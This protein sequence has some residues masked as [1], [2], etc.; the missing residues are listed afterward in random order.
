MK[1]NLKK[2]KV[3]ELKKEVKIINLKFTFKE[4]KEFETID[5]DISK[6]E[7]KIRKL[8]NDMAKNSIKLW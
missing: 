2:K 7:E 4:Q 3:K 5:E 1:I 6:L 8:E